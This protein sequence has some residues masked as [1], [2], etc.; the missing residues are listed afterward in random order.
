MRAFL[1]ALLLALA[2]ATVMAEPAT[3]GGSLYVMKLAMVDQ[4]GAGIGLDRYRG[5]PVLISLFYASCTSACPLLISAIQQIE[6]RQA[7][8]QR[9]KLRVLLVTLDPDHDTPA[10]LLKI[11]ALHRVDVS[12]WTLARADTRSLRKLAAALG[13]QYRRQPNGEFNHSTVITL[14]DP[15]G[16]PVEHTDKVLGRDEAFEAEIGRLLAP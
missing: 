5:S 16:R 13:I 2:P 11:A 4:A 9:A 8:A 1:A 10:E 3:P 14:L 6:G 7:P 12:R 15:D